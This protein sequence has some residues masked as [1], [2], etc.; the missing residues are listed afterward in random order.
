MLKRQLQGFIDFIREQ[1]FIKLAV[2]FLLGGSV[3]KM[4]TS[5]VTDII[6]PILSIFLG[7]TSNL[8]DMYWTIGDVK[9]TYGNFLNN[10]VDF[11]TIALVIYFALNLVKIDRLDKKKEVA[12]EAARV[13]VE[14][15]EQQKRLERKG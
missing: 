6:N 5:L 4:V 11:L 15:E 10:F 3:S 8:K 2:A 12:A 13:K 9:I 7:A 14:K 1:G